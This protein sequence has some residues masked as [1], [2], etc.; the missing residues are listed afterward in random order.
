MQLL[1]I[2]LYNAGGDRRILEFEPGALNVVTGESKTGKSALLEIVEYCL[3]R[4]T[5]LMPVGPITRT[6]SWYAAL[7]D[8]DGGRAFVARPAPLPGKASTQ[9]AMLEFGANLEP[10][11]FTDLVVNADSGSIRE[12]L[13][14]R[15]G[16]E[17]NLHQPRTGSGWQPVEAHIGHAALLCLQRQGEIANRDLLFH[18]QGD[19]GIAQ[20]LKDTIPYFLGAVARDQAL[21][22]AQ[23]SAA[24]RELR[25]AD[26]ALRE[27]E[28]TI[29]TGDVNLRALWHE[30]YAAG[31]VADQ[32]LP[33]SRTAAVAALQAAISAPEPVIP[34]DR[35]STDR[36]IA[37][38][39]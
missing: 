24:R 36:A 38:Q 25:E 23:L 34:V 1:A 18:R 3:G 21:K 15:I 26:A 22:R 2:I 37:L 35:Q 17:E 19:Q 31:M 30:A 13:G 8:L 39:S 28:Q 7:F 32:A 16:I 27:A 6:V 11:E 4:G 9:R 20:T 14:R 10:L 33:D 5:M 12:Q 29:E